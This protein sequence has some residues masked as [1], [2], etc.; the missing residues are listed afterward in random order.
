[1][2]ENYPIFLITDGCVGYDKNIKAVMSSTNHIRLT[3]IR[4]KR[5]NNNICERLNGMIRARLKVRRGMQNL[6]TADLMTEA[7]ANYYNPIK[8]HF[9]LGTTPAIASGIKG[10]LEGGRWLGLIINAINH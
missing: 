10:S 1:M 2:S 5:T 8:I 7:F 3:S 4:D 9:V 6:G